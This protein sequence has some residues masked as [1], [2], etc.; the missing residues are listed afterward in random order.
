M[1][2]A[3]HMMVQKSKLSV[4]TQMVKDPGERHSLLWAFAV[5]GLAAGFVVPAR[6]RTLI[7]RAL[8]MR[9]ST[10]ALIRP[11]V[12]IRSSN[13]TIGAKST[14]N[15]NCVFDNRGGV[16]IGRNV[17]IGVGVHFLT[18]DHDSSDPLRRAGAGFST[19]IVVEDGVYIGSGA[20]ILAGVRIH[21]GAVVAAGA[22][23]TRDCQAD[24]LY[25]GIP[26]RRIRDLA[27]GL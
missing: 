11:R 6:V 9:I 18:T 13:I 4:F 12:I 15:Y 21:Q 20:T 2:K 24:G 10:R 19:E 14:V 5:N 17:G 7:L 25:A 23:V 26:A 3:L 16:T 8:G 1:N 27:T 22:V